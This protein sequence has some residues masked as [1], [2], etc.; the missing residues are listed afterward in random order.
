MEL[1]FAVA[2]IEAWDDPGPFDVI[3]VN[4]VLQWIPDH[5]GLLP[6]LVSRLAS[7]GALARRGGELVLRGAALSVRPSGG[8]A[9][10][11]LSPDEGR[12]SRDRRMVQG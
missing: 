4:A 1:R 6:A 8:L 7:G 9:D 2:G 11:L 12:R 3:L 5:A 10:H